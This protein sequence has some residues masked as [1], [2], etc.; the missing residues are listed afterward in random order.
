FTAHGYRKR[1]SRII[2]WQA[3]HQ[4]IGGLHGN[5]AHGRFAQVLG[6]LR[7]NLLT[8]AI[9]LTTDFECVI[10][11]R[12]VTTGELHIHHWP[13]NLHDFASAHT[14]SLS[15]KFYRQGGPPR[16]TGGTIAV[17]STPPNWRG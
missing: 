1:L 8:A 5:G 11:G 3:A 12:Q 15:R 4:A 2:H 6:D 17:R 10:D 14:P 13:D 7:R 9:H 16:Q